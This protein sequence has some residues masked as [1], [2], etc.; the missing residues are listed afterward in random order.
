MSF[1]YEESFESLD[2]WIRRPADH[3]DWRVVN[4]AFVGHWL[5]R[6][7][8][9]LFERPV[10][11]DASLEV[12][13]QVLPFDWSRTLEAQREP[14]PAAWAAKKSAE[15]SGQKNFNVL[16]MASGPDGEDFHEAF[17]EWFG[18]GKMGLEFFRTYFFTFTLLWARLR[19]CPGYEL[20]SDQ[21]NVI[22]E[23]GKDYRIQI[24]QTGNRLRYR[25]NGDL[26]HD[27]TDPNAYRRGRVGFVLSTSQVRVSRLVIDSEE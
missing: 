8:T 2:H 7:N 9:L 5:E 23:V 11:G 15:G 20:M 1:H 27:F 10:G 22:S 25:L 19:R 13:I 26:V 21:Q 24:E 12:D 14:D 17:D 6:G 4:G 18:Q 3:A 16:W